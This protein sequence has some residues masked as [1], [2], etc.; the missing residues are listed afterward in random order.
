[1]VGLNKFIEMTN[2]RKIHSFGPPSTPPYQRL[3]NW[4]GVAEKVFNL[5][6]PLRNPP[7]F[8]GG[9]AG[10]GVFWVFYKNP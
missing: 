9:S 7:F 1:M 2:I 8:R 6:A 4:G 3:N 10:G 5:V